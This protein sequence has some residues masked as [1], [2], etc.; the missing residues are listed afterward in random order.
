MKKLEEEY[1]KFIEGLAQAHWGVHNDDAL[2][3][4]T[5]LY[6]LW[7]TFL[8]GADSIIHRQ[9]IDAEQGIDSTPELHN[10]IEQIL[11]ELANGL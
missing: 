3:G 7:A 11:K 1:L 2:V 10:D 4:E 5:L 8:A 9:I 6:L